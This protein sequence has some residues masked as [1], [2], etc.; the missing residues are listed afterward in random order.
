MSTGRAR[1]CVVLR[2]DALVD[3]VAYLL[4]DDAARLSLA[5]RFAILVIKT[6]PKTHGLPSIEQIAFGRYFRA[7]ISHRYTVCA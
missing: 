1:P 5:S 7:A 4:P 2:G 3:V 6:A